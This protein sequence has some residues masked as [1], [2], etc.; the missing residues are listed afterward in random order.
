LNNSPPQVR[1]EEAMTAI[2]LANL[3]PFQKV[4][5]RKYQQEQ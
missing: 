5:L 2:P 4:A 3:L 1:K